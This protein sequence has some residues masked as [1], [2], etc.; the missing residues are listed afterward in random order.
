MCVCVYVVCVCVYVC[1]VCV[2]MNT[3]EVHICTYRISACCVHVCMNVCACVVYICAPTQEPYRYHFPVIVP[4]YDGHFHVPLRPLLPLVELRLGESHVDVVPHIAGEDDVREPKLVGDGGHL[5]VLEVWE[6]PLEGVQVPSE[7]LE[8]EE[9]GALLLATS[10]GQLLHH[11]AIQGS[12][13][14]LLAL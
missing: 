13:L 6:V 4:H 5:R 8:V 12:K 14:V 9:D 7:H 10:A 11:T 1:G 2:H 3:A